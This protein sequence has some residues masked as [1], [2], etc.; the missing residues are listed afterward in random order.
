[1][2]KIL[3]ILFTCCFSILH[4]QS[5]A[6]QNALKNYDYELAIQL[7]SKEKKSADMDFLKAKC[8]KNIAQYKSAISLLEEIVR[9]NPTNIAAV[10]ELAESYQLSGNYSKSKFFYFMALQSAPNNRFAQLNYLNSLFKLRDWK[11]TIKFA[12]PILKKDSLPV[13]YPIL[14]DCYLQV[15]KPD[16]SIYFYRKAL[17][18][19][20]E[21][22]NTLSKL[23]NIY[24]LSSDYDALLKCTTN[25][26]QID[27]SNQ[28]INQHNGIGHCMKKNHPQAIYRLNK[29][30]QQ[31]D[32][33]FITHFY[34]GISYFANNDNPDAYFHLKQALKKD[35]SNVTVY[36][37]LGKAAIL[38]GHQ[39]EGIAYLNK[40]I[41]KI[42]PKDSVLYNYNYGI[43]KGYELLGNIPERIK[44]LK[45]SSKL[46][47]EQ[48]SLLYII[49]G[50]Y[51]HEMKRYDEALEYYN[52]FMA[53]RPASENSHNQSSGTGSYYNA[54]EYR[55]KEI[56]DELNAKKGK[57]KE[58][59]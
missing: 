6:I 3:F 32:S 50:I 55:I 33:S 5:N 1:M 20:S 4:A 47:P 28:V 36:Y 42:T 12:L 19:N 16:S 48:K 56:K 46:K 37:Y 35:S 25:Y 11:S 43:A 8:H 13:L 14:G 29:L 31:G 38:S 49:A 10:N 39:P 15:L 45:I 22:Y 23:S 59:E 26:M 53:T 17:K 2:R 41:N 58:K 21:D 54:T 44:H 24:L 51:D 57:R 9:Q 18:N 34:L 27:S 40:G 52:L 7:I 30:Y